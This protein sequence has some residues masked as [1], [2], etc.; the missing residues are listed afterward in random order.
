MKAIACGFII[1]PARNFQI[2]I[3]DILIK[4]RDS[5]KIPFFNLTTFRRMESRGVKAIRLG[6]RFMVSTH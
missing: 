3:N 5:K 2:P 1:G 6:K 4:S